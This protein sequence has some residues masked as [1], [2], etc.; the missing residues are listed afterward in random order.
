MQWMHGTPASDARFG[1][2]LVL[3]IVGGSF[4]VSVSLHRACE[5]SCFPRVAFR[6]RSG[7]RFAFAFHMTEASNSTGNVQDRVFDV[8]ADE[9]VLPRDSL[10]RAMTLLEI[11]DSLTRVETV[12]ELEDAFEIALPDDEID[13]VRTLGELVDVVDAKLRDRENAGDR[14]DRAAD[15]DHPPRS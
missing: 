10:D 13:H 2:S 12:M 9:C 7:L 6:M 11:G 1:E 15:D 4:D 8:V 3:V 5:R 14:D